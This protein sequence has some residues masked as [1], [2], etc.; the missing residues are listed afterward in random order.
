[1]QF[2]ETQ[3]I[4]APRDFVFGRLVDANEIIDHLPSRVSLRNA[5]QLQQFIKGSLWVAKIQRGG[6]VFTINNIIVE[7]QAPA[8]LNVSSES[9]RL[10]VQTTIS[11]IEIDPETTEIRFKLELAPKGLLGRILM[12]TIRSSRTRI[13]RNFS[14]G[15]GRLAR[16]FE[17]QYR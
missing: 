5:Q 13:S 4:N 11:L 15:L 16:Y 1:M 8:R 9:N 12:Q 10:M 3:T 6:R 14:D 2:M 7:S 17:N